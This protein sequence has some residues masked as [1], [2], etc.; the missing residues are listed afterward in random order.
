MIR[1]PGLRSLAAAVLIALAGLAAPASALTNVALESERVLREISEHREKALKIL[2]I[3]N[4]HTRLHDVRSRLARQLAARVGPERV[5]VVGRIARDGARLFDAAGRPDVVAAL[6]LTDWDIVVIQEATASFLYPTGR[7]AFHSALGWFVGNTP[8][9]ARLVLF[10]TWPWI[11]RHRLYRGELPPAY[12]RPRDAAEMWDWM[13]THYGAAARRH[14][15]AITPAP[16]GRC[17]RETRPD[18][19]YSRDG[20][21]ASETGAEY[22]AIV[23]ADTISRAIGPNKGSVIPAQNSAA[24]PPD[25]PPPPRL[26]RVR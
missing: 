10:E 8:A 25:C 3:G 5:P 17:W 9:S 16:V 6:A 2:L 12:E 22:T 19:Y 7:E 21:H 1:R 18:L 23:L 15:A 11:E 20:N 14:G 4:S 24:Q 26:D 13:A